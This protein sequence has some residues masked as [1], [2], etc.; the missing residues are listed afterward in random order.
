MVVNK[1]TFHSIYMVHKR[2]L[3]FT[4]LLSYGFAFCQISCDLL[5]Q[6][7]VLPESSKLQ[8]EISVNKHNGSSQCQHNNLSGFVIGLE[9]F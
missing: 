4:S 5:L 9:Y 1:Y 3:T 6:L 8:S 2:S 7:Q